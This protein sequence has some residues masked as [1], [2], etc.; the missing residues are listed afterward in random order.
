MRRRKRTAGSGECAGRG[1]PPSAVPSTRRNARPEA[2]AA[3]PPPPPPPPP[4]AQEIGDDDL[5]AR[6]MTGVRPL[7]ADARQ[8]VAPPP[9]A[10]DAA[11]G[12]RRGQRGAG[13]AVRS[14]HRRSGR[15]ISPTPSSSSR[16]PSPA[17]I[18]A[19]CA[20]CA[21]GE[22]AYQAH[23]DLHGMTAEEARVAVDTL[24]HPRP[25]AGTALRADRPRPRPELEGSGPG[26]EDA[27]GQWLARGS[28]ARLVL[29]FTSARP[30]DGGAGALYVAAPAPAP[31]GPRAPR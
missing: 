20:S 24:P 3:P 14:R 11:P 10:P 28:W 4:L 26:A 22:F 21:A 25:P 15:S 8:R 9:P 6:E 27:P 30:C 23:L 16:A 12:H 1:L 19:W 18:A 31:H 13:R 7:S 5:F 2:P 29:A 17:S